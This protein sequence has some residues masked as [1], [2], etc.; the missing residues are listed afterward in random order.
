MANVGTDR[1]VRHADGSVIDALP[2][3]TLV[4]SVVVPETDTFPSNVAGHATSKP[5]AGAAV[6]MPIPVPPALKSMTKA[7]LVRTMVFEATTVPLT[8]RFTVTLY[9]VSVSMALESVGAAP[10]LAIDVYVVPDEVVE[11]VN[12]VAVPPTGVTVPEIVAS[13][14]GFSHMHVTSA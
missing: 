7:D 12:V 13:L 1:A 2:N 8:V 14:F 6:P 4:P 5:L 3:V 11:N 10:G 9:W